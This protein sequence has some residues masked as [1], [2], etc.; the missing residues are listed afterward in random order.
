M[1]IRDLQVEDIKSLSE[2]YYQFWNENSDIQKMKTKFIKLHND[3][4][5][6]FLCAIENEKLVGSVMG[7]VC[8]ELY[9]DCKPFL[10]IENMIVD[11]TCRKKGVGK[12]LFAEL[13]KRAKDRDC[14]QIILVT[15][16]EREDA[17]G[18]YESVGFHPTMHKGSKKKLLS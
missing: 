2:L 13:E 9:G 1:T 17:C 18:F 16:T 12:T 8:E 4:T 3:S 11:K 14:T 7:I 15:E 6:I 10:V 5:Y